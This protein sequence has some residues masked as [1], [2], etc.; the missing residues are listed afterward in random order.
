MRNPNP[1]NFMSSEEVR[2]A[3]WQAES[4]DSDGHLISMHAPFEA[5]DD[6]GIVWF[7]REATKRGE[8]VTIWPIPD[9]Q[10]KGAA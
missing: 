7:V 10:I 6:E 3:G 2:S 1:V 5:H 8:T 9:I 4:R